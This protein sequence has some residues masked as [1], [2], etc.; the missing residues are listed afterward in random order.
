MLDSLQF[1]FRFYDKFDAAEPW[2]WYSIGAQDEDNPVNITLTDGSYSGDLC[3]DPATKSAGKGS[4]QIEN[5][6]GGTV[7]MTVNLKTKKV[8]FTLVQ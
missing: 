5:W 4:W 2:D 7:E 3:Y 8:A 1:Q 6:P